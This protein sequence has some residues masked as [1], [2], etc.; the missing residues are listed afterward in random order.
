MGVKFLLLIFK[1]EVNSDPFFTWLFFIVLPAYT[2]AEE[3]QVDYSIDNMEE[4]V[5]WH[6]TSGCVSDGVAA[7]Q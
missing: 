2:M 7:T 3:E 1:L 4:G 6:S 5:F